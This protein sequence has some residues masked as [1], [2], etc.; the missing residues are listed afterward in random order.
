M[1]RL[2]LFIYPDSYPDMSGYINTYTVHPK[3]GMKDVKEHL[4]RMHTEKA[5]CPSASSFMHIMVCYLLKKVQSTTDDAR[6]AKRRLMWNNFLPTS[7]QPS[8]GATSP[9]SYWVQPG[10]C[11]SEPCRG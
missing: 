1:M 2:L 9:Y 5:S 11:F 3:R 7:P 10:G 8:H 6:H 4:I